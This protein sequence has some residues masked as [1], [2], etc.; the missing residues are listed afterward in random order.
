MRGV[1]QGEGGEPA[2]RR[3]RPMAVDLRLSPRR[4]A[5]K[6]KSLCAA[7]NA[8]TPAALMTM[9]ATANAFNESPSNTAPSSA[10][11]MTSNLEKVVP[12][13]K[14]RNENIHSK[15]TVNKIWQTPPS[16]Q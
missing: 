8:T 1:V 15:N 10:T 5:P 14:L 6:V 7:L 9:A 3:Q 12:T 11:M 2:N 4:S 16:R 13:A